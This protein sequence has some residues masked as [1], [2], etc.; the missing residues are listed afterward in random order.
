[1]AT[2]SRILA[3]RIPWIEEPD[4]LQSKEPQRVRHNW[5]FEPTIHETSH[6]SDLY[7]APVLTHVPL[8]VQ[9]SCVKYT[10]K[11]SIKC[12]KWK[13]L[14]TIFRSFHKKQCC[15]A[16]RVLHETHWSP[17]RNTNNRGHRGKLALRRCHQVNMRSLRSW[18]LIWPLGSRGK[19]NG[20]T[21][22]TQGRWRVE[23]CVCKLRKARLPRKLEK[24]REDL[25]APLDA[26]V[27]PRPCWLLDPGLLA[28]RTLRA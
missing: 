11:K 13:Y 25:L 24:V 12:L 16:N 28:P 3:W 15:G 9:C 7:S 14:P 2:H 23:W 18:S 27:T 20:D 5:V 26:L 6:S 19:R 8:P 21:K 4:G 1:M 10:L 17:D 22:D